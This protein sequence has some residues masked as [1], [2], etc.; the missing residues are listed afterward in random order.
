MDAAVEVGRNTVCKQQGQPKYEDEKAEV[1]R[2]H[3]TRFARPNVQ[4]RTGTV[5]YYF[6]FSVDH[7]QD[8]QPYLVDLYSCICSTMFTS[9]MY[10]AKMFPSVL[11]CPC[12]IDISKR[13]KVFCLA[14][15]RKRVL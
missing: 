15:L 8:W 12:A 13:V 3:R 1:G 4:A 11:G 14:L 9:S 6:S 2:D 10:T 5:K 7:E